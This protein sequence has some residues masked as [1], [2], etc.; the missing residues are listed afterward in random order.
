MGINHDESVA[1]DETPDP[2]GKN[3][4]VPDPNDAQSAPIPFAHDDD[5]DKAD[6]D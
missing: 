5:D 2:H 1:P 3:T 6:S 4:A